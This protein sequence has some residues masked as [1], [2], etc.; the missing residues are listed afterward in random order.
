VQHG[1]M[2]EKRRN[3]YPS[4]VTEEEWKFVLP[5]LLLCREGAVQREHDLREVFNSMRYVALSGCT[6]RMVPGDLLPWAA[7]YQQMRRW[8]D[9][10]YFEV[11]VA[12]VQIDYVP[13][14]RA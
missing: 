13:V 6:W 7:V 10:G 8:I 1:G 14:G 9:Q 2:G 12:D 3:G 4:D 11:L 5:Y